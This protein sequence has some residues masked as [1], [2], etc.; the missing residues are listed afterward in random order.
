MVPGRRS[1]R[2]IT[3]PLVAICGT[4]LGDTKDAASMLGKPARDRRST[5]S[6][7]TAP[8]TDSFSFCRPSRGP[9]STILTLFGKAFMSVSPGAV[10]DVGDR[11]AVFELADLGG[12]L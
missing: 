5:S 9:T 2:A 12:D 6:T 8:D 3:S 11:F 7:L 4:H 10:D 1:I